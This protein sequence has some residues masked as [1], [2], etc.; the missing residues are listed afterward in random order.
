MLVHNTIIKP[1][2]LDCDITSN[3]YLSF[4]NCPHGKGN[5][6]PLQYSCLENPMDGGAWWAT[7]HGVAKSL[8]WLIDFTFTPWRRKWQPTPVFCLENPRDGGAWWAAVYG[9]PQ[10]WTRLKQL[11]SSSNCPQN[12]ICSYFFPIQDPTKDTAL[13]VVVMALQSSIIQSIFPIFLLSVMSLTFSCRMSHNLNF[14]I[15][16][17]II[18]FRINIFPRIHHRL[19]H[20]FPIVLH[21]R[22]CQFD[23]SLITWLTKLKKTELQQNVCQKM[24]LYLWT[25]QLRSLR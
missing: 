4:S 6:N 24:R 15:C 11:N 1:M 14:Y 22:I 19:W 12:T 5:G 21:Q 16:F 20:I 8:T 3:P 7:I 13:H 18:R 23:E 2:K 17:L 10:S 25:I 9:V